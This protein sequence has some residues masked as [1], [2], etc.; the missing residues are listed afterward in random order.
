MDTMSKVLRQATRLRF[1]AG[2]FRDIA[3]RTD[4]LGAEENGGGAGSFCQFGGAKSAA[5]LKNRSSVFS[6][7]SGRRC[8]EIWRP[9][10]R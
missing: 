5:A 8:S 2:A 9:R 1:L 6:L 4:L 3:S 10:R 7:G